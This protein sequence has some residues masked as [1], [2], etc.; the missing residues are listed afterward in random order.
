M[1]KKIAL[2]LHGG[3]GASRTLEYSA[4]L[5]DMRGLVE[6]ARDRLARGDSALDVAVAVVA[7]MEASGLYVAGK[8]G[9]PNLAGEYELDACLMD[10]STGL[11][12]AVAS[13]QGFESPVAVARLIMEKTPHV[14]LAGKGAQAFALSH[15]A[16][17]ISGDGWFTHAGAGESNYSPG[18]LPR[19][20]VGCSVLDGEGR[21]AAA[22]SSGGVFDKMPGR[23]GDSPIIGAGAW[24]DE[25]VAISCTGQG[26]LFIRRA[27]AAQIAFRMRFGETLQMA[28]DATLSEIAALGGEGGLAAV[29]CH[30]NVY[31]PYNAEG[32]KRAFLNSNGQIGSAIFD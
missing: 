11:A 12:G 19:G 32:M 8:G 18:V 29:D 20:T 30:G 3:A 2:A 22:T 23:I 13:L 7:E 26:E 10:G 24:A 15:G 1:K 17:E 6:A 5:A 25:R 16:R 14:M 4:I 21:L 31:L 27:A 9:S 28:A